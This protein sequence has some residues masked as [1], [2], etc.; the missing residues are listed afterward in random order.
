MNL[1][2]ILTV[3]PYGDYWRRSRKLMH[4]QT[5]AKAAEHYRPNQ[6]RGARRFVG[7]LLAVEPNRPADKLSDAAKAVLPRMVRYNFA[8]TALDMIYGIDVQDN[9]AEA[10]YVEAA[11]RTLHNFSQGT[12]PG[13]FAVDY[14]PLCKY[15][16]V[17]AF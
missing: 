11:E 15:K 6:I 7:D 3:I 5:H 13:Q 12:S 4:S 1:G 14:I 8:Y 16:L 10:R 2:W 17:L 9:A